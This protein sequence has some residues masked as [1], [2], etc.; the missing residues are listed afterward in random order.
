MVDF[1][2]LNGPNR[3]QHHEAL[4]VTNTFRLQHRYNLDGYE[5]GSRVLKFFSSEFLSV[6]S[7]WGLI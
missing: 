4:V 1:G 6:P 3:H 5:G 7:S 2:D